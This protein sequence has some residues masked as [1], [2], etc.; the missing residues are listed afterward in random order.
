MVRWFYRDVEL[1][2]VGE[3]DRTIPALAAS[4]GE[5]RKRNTRASHVTLAIRGNRTLSKPKT[6]QGR[7]SRSA[8]TCGRLHRLFFSFD[9]SKFSIAKFLRPTRGEKEE[10]RGVIRFASK[11]DVNKREKEREQDS[12]KARQQDSRTKQKRAGEETK[13]FIGRER[14]IR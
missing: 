9:V 7:K 10:S 3:I 11:E 12:N 8:L 14:L 4:A 6:R 13:C 1:L 5:M 2:V